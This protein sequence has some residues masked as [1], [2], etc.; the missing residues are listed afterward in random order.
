MTT[1]LSMLGLGGNESLPPNMVQRLP[2]SL[3]LTRAISTIDEIP[4]FPA[5]KVAVIYG[6][7]NQQVDYSAVSPGFVQ[8]TNKLGDLVSCRQLRYFSGGLDTSKN[9]LDGKFALVWNDGKVHKD[10]EIMPSINAM[11][12]FH[13]I[14]LMPF[15]VNGRKRHFGNDLVHIIYVDEFSQMHQ[16]FNWQT[17]H[18]G[19]FQIIACTG[20]EGK[21]HL[22]LRI[23]SDVDPSLLRF[24]GHMLG[25]SIIDAQ[26]AGFVVRQIAIRASLA[27]LLH[28][29]ELVGGISNWEARLEQL[30]N[31]PQFTSLIQ[32]LNSYS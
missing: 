8:F 17:G 13:D 3:K 18:F 16:D 9:A 32:I 22:S 30:Q 11:V 20:K 15:S 4:P 24:V 31:L 21:L 29:E 5:F 19:I 28:F 2:R 26:D 7:G 14:S 25:D 12:L 1:I 6:C 10:D 27:C 23:R